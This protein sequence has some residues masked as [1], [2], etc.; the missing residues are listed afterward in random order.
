MLMHGRGGLPQTLHGSL[1]L[2][3]SIKA[4]LKNV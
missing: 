3:M 1:V 4:A 2:T